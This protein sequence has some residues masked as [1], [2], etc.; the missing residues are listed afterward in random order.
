MQVEE[1]EGD[2]GEEAEQEDEDDGEQKFVRGE[3]IGEFAE[4]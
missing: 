3:F 1:G 2:D 4:F